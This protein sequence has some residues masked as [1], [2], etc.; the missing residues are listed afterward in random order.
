[1]SGGQRRNVRTGRSDP[2]GTGGYASNGWLASVR[3]TLPRTVT[4]PWNELDSRAYL[5]YMKQSMA[6]L[7]VTLLAAGAAW[8]GAEVGPPAPVVH[9]QASTAQQPRARNFRTPA[10][11][12]GGLALAD[13]TTTEMALSRGAR[14][15][16]PLMRRR[17]ARIGI[18]AAVWVLSTKVDDMLSQKTRKRNV[19]LVRGVLIVGTGYVVSRNV[20]AWSAGRR[21]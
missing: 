4:R 16:N 8:A 5:S 17:A 3:V 20:Q 14:E 2:I 15:A 21:R 9:L 18:E 19:W 10:L 1:M 11:L 12:Y 6:L 7:V 13:Y